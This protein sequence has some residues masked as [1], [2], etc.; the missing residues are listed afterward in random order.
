MGWQKLITYAGFLWRP[1]WETIQILL[2][3][4]LLVEE[5]TNNGMVVL[6]EHC[7]GGDISTKQMFL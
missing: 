6:G 7:K 5:N 1:G 4:V 2:Y 3:G